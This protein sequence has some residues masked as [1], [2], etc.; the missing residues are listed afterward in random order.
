MMEEPHERKF[1]AHLV[2][3]CVRGMAIL[4]LRLQELQ[5]CGQVCLETRYLYT[6]G[7]LLP[8]AARRICLSLAY[9]A[10]IISTLKSTDDYNF[11]HA[12]KGSSRSVSANLSQL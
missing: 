12:Y 9:A 4:D 2:R 11:E 6:M 3:L 10:A 1:K 7:L 5:A 8:H